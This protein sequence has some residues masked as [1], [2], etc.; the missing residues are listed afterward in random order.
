MT[1]SLMKLALLV[2][3]LAASQTYAAG[4]DCSKKVNATERRICANDGLSALD[5]RLQ[6]VWKDAV[7]AVTAPSQSALLTEQRHWI[8][9]VRNVCTE[10]DCLSDAYRQ[11]IALL[12]RNDKYLADRAECSIVEGNSCRSVVYYRDSAARFDSFRR[13]LASH[14][15]K[16]RLLG[17]DRLIDLPVGTASGNHSFGASCT[18]QR[19]KARVSVMLC[20][21]EMVG[22]YALREVKPGAVS[23]EQLVA[24]TDN[25]CFGG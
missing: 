20:E 5:D 18:L 9:Y 3:A 6:V 10:D 21:D 14:G 23:T 15:E 24:F 22:H 8:K 11:R 12:E 2:A 16:G 17:C 19:G 7:A 4:F 25:E 1:P 13:A